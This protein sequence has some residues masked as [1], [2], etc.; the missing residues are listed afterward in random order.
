[1]LTA[2]LDIP[3]I[4]FPAWFVRWMVLQPHAIATKGTIDGVCLALR[5]GWAINLS[6]GFTHCTTTFG[7][8]FNV[9]PDIILAIH[10]AKKWHGAQCQRILV[11][12]T[13]ATQANGIARELPNDD[14]VYLCDIYDP[15]ISPKDY[16]SRSRINQS[17][18]VGEFDT[19]ESYISKVNHRV[20]LAISTFAPDFVI[21]NAGYDVLYGDGKGKMKISESVVIFR[22][23][24]VFR[25]CKEASDIPVLMTT[26]GCYQKRQDTVIARSIR[27]LV[28]K[29]DLSKKPLNIG[30]TDDFR[31][32]YKMARKGNAQGLN[33]RDAFEAT[34]SRSDNF[35][36]S[37][38]FTDPN[39]RDQTYD[40]AGRPGQFSPNSTSNVARRG[41]YGAGLPGASR[42]T[43][44]KHPQQ[45]FE[46]DSRISRLTDGLINKSD[47]GVID[48][49]SYRQ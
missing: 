34:A 22:D 46:T 3:A 26:G 30:A 49:W 16:D 5:H 37:R 33:Q 13:S 23:E 9:Y 7:D 44:N 28:V 31:M 38:V 11:I 39:I 17:A 47:I 36:G 45:P 42:K 4:F 48:N 10:Y 25:L 24:L 19:D 41:G 35:Q 8:M 21:Y 14:S 43:G 40:R 20:G 29:F 6:G 27:N 12:D 18:T 15:T 1:M 32:M 2:Y